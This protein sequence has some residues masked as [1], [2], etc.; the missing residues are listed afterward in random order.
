MSDKNVQMPVSVLNYSSLTQLLRNP[1]IF[2]IRE[3]LGVYTGK[4]SVSSMIGSA[5]H[6]ALKVY[7]GGSDIAVPLDPVEARTIAI[8]AGIKY[9]DDY[10]DD[11]IRYGKKGSR[12][13]ILQGFSR[14]MQFYFQ[15]EPI[16]HEIVMCEEKMTGRLMTTDGQELPLP[17]SGQADLVHR[18]KEG[19]CEIIDAKFVKQFTRYEDEDGEPHED[20]IKIIQAQFMIHL[21]KAYKGIEVDRV[22]FR[23]IKYT[24]NRPCIE[25]DCPEQ[26]DPQ[27]KHRQVRD[28]VIPANHE[29]YR[30]IFYN[31]YR[32]VVKF[33]S[34]PDVIFL[35]N[36]SDPFDGEMAGLLYAQG[37]INADMSDVEVMHRVRE[38]AFTT[39]KFVPSRL[40]RAENQTL[41]PEERVKMKLYEFGIIVEPQ[42]TK[43]GAN[44]TQYRFKVSAGT[45]MARIRKHRDDIAQALAQKGDVRILTPIPGTSYLGIEV[46][47]EKRTSQRLR[48]EHLIPNTLSLPIGTDV[49]GDVTRVPLDAMPHLL[50]AGSTGSGKSYVVNNILE[51]L[52]KQMT[53]EDMRLVLIDPKR[54]ELARFNKKPHLH[55]RKVIFDHDEAIIELLKLTGIMDKRY[56][57]LEHHGK[58]DIEEFNKSKR[59]KELRMPYIV[60]VIDEFADLM[61][62]SKKQKKNGSSKSYGSKSKASL[63]R[64]LAKRGMFVSDNTPVDKDTLIQLL[65]EDDQNNPLKGADA[66]AE[67]LMVRLA[68]LG[69]AAGIHLIVAT[70][71][72]SVDVITGLIKANFPTRIALTTSSPVDSTVILGKPGAEK[73]A[74]S[75]DMLFMHPALKGEVRLQG[76]DI[77]K[78]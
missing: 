27:K 73:L 60:V 18:R 37:L 41:L 16:Y 62:R 14:A 59:N 45:S 68:Q 22:I 51:A 69:R 56:S 34:N 61:L 17:A 75:G 5:G 25:K 24:E 15:E 11:G 78:K 50:I 70:Q 77:A 6:E 53:P 10:P 52:T 21:A 40:D 57:D 38:V 35:P 23:E 33:L 4:K 3:I 36:L 65:E 72:P 9:I 7:Y 47:S 32:D 2:K 46:E 67:F 1:I 28:Y 64:E 74:G 44:V 8:A 42:E 29:P 31:L 30:I 55:G 39:K 54:V 66:D 26:H 49:D 63:A 13:Q 48:K 76:F 12:E 19:V 43:V 20:Y 71:R 58:R